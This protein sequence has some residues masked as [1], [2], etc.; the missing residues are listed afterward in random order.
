MPEDDRPFQIAIL[1]YPGVKALNAVGPWQVFSRML[2]AQVRFVGE[3]LGPTTTE[4]GA[5]LLGI[6]HTL[7]ETPSP[8]LVSYREA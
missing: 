3:E 6:S 8:D 7:A 4:G 1:L 2:N 5:L